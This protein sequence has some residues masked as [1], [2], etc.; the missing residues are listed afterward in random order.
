VPLANAIQRWPDLFPLN[1]LYGAGLVEAC[2]ERPA[3]EALRHA[4]QLNPQDPATADLLH[5]VTNSLASK[6]QAPVSI[7][8][9]FAIMTKPL[10][11]GLKIR[12]FTAAWRKSTSPWAVGRKR[13][14][15]NKK[16]TA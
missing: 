16:L 6:S 1:A 7:P 4:H 3:Y 8:F 13:R 15:N 2:Q 14:Q 9:R 5:T 12:K 11:F 10:D